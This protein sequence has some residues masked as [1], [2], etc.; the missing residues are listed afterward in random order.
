MIG[1]SVSHYKIVEKVGEGG[2][3]VVYKAH[4]QELDRFVALKFLPSH[5]TGDEEQRKRFMQEAKAVSSLDHPNV[6]TIYEINRTPEGQLFIVMAYYEGSTLKNL[7]QKGPLPLEK[8]LR[9]S[10]QIARGLSRAHEAKIT[11]R[12]LKPANVIVTK[13]DDAKI[14]DFGLAKLA[15]STGLTRTG[16][17]MGTVAYMSPEQARGSKVDHRT[18]IWS[19]G[20]VMYE[21]IAGERPFKGDFE[22]AVIY[23]ILNE[24]ELR[25][26]GLVPDVPEPVTRVVHR[27][28]CKDPDKRSASMRDVLA[29]LEPLKVQVTGESPVTGTAARSVPKKRKRSWVG[30]VVGGVLIP[31]AALVIFLAKPDGEGDRDTAVTAREASHRA[32]QAAVS[33]GARE[34][35]AGEIW[36]A[37]AL[38]SRASAEFDA[39]RFAQATTLFE[40]ATTKFG[41]A[42]EAARAGKASG[43]AEKTTVKESKPDEIAQKVPAHEP[44]RLPDETSVSKDATRQ[45]SPANPPPVVTT[46][47][48]HSADAKKARDTMQQAKAQLDRA[49]G[50]EK[51]ED[52]VEIGNA[53]E[54]ERQGEQS[55]AN[56]DYDNAI[57]QFGLA[58]VRYRGAAESAARAMED[59]RKEA[60][61]LRAGVRAMRSGMPR[62]IGATADV[63]YQEGL[64]AEQEGDRSFEGGRF[65]TALRRYENAS[66]RYTT[67]RTTRQKQIAEVE[68]LVGRYRAALEAEDLRALGTL[69]VDFT[70]KMR[71][72]WSDFFGQVS[73]LRAQLSV[74]SI[75]FDTSR[76]T[77]HVTVQ[78]SYSGARG[79]KAHQWDMVMS[80]RDGRWLI[81]EVERQ[82]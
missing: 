57:E 48:D 73:G 46:A 81:A 26:S 70:D 38:M 29:E 50:G 82:P 60:E 12:D 19:L 47:S 14:L 59:A 80:Q 76:A 6:C 40:S 79:E 54:V 35:A 75:G 72:D 58:A 36:A 43:D 39:G 52:V 18:D 3:G 7:L 68:S 45:P 37:D 25:L 71:S 20:V 55:L 33:E 28:L 49:T 15:H 62:D 32:E 74:D 2:M 69:H 63:A 9:Y 61:T 23:S 31:A 4:D 51:V 10:V 64:A 30:P 53:V 65:K 42:R 21:M 44:P 24:E 1:T 13:H 41:A 66:A 56:A 78:F 27:A 77:V 11:H 34:R 8:V 17:T 67:A 5:L 22:Q 16:A